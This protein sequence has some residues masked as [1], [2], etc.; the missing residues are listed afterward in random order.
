MS[1]YLTLNDKFTSNGYKYYQV[2][3]V[4]GIT[5]KCYPPYIKGQDDCCW[6]KLLKT[7]KFQP[8]NKNW[9]EQKTG[10]TLQP[11]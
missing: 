6:I 9:C 5:I 8:N 1:K 4:P 7:E 2:W 10:M 11:L 3:F